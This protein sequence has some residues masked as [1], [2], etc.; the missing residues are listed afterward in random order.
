M[1]R[2][3]IIIVGEANV[4]KKTFIKR[5][6]GYKFDDEYNETSVDYNEVLTPWGFYILKYRN[7]KNLKKHIEEN[8]EILKKYKLFSIMLDYTNLKS[9][10]N[11]KKYIILTKQIKNINKIILLIN[12]YEN[13]TKSKYIDKFIYPFMS[14]KRKR[15]NIEEIRI[16][17]KYYKGLS[18]F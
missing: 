9:F 10:N 12:K 13:Q 6:M 17:S 1:E 16:T 14:Y 5:V 4:G 15:Y 18:L 7:I 8:N 3:N 2:Q 11:L